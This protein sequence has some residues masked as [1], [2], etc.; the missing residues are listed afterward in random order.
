MSPTVQNTLFGGRKHAQLS[1]APDI[2]A[3]EIATDFAPFLFILRLACADSENNRNSL[4]ARRS[5]GQSGNS[6]VQTGS[7]VEKL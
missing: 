2:A 6:R 4:A 5:R 7:D 1:R 3:E